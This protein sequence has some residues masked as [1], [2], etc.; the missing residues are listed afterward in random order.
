[1]DPVVSIILTVIVAAFAT[2]VQSGF[3]FGEALIAMPL[4]TLFLPITVATPIVAFFGFTISMSISLSSLKDIDFGAAWRLILM[5]LIGIPIGLLFLKS[6]SEMLIKQIL[7]IVLMLFGLYRI[8]QPRLVELKNPLWAYAFGLISGI[9]GGAYNTNGPPIVIYAVMRGWD[10]KKF[11]ATLQGFFF[12]SGFMI[13]AGHG[14]SGLWTP[15][16]FKLF[17]ICLPFILFAVYLGGRMNAKLAKPRFEKMLNY[18]IVVL[19]SIMLL[20]A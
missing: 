5:S 19:G 13:L 4:L 1:M 18:L 9:L 6:G 15:D 11:R 17:G 3:G 14:I 8:F 16:V 12:I 10:P 20:T 2:F 7:G